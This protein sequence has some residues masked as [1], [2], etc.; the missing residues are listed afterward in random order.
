M[1]T[2]LLA[3]TALLALHAPVFAEVKYEFAPDFLTPPPGKETIGSGHGE[4]G[5]DAAGNIYVSVEGQK[6]GG[7]Q[8]YS[9][10]GKYLRNLKGVP[11]TLHGFVIHKDGDEEFIYAA[12][13][14]Q[15][16][17]LKMK[18]DGTVVLE[19]PKESFPEQQAKPVTIELKGGG[20]VA[21]H[22]S[23]ETATDV[24]V[25]L[26]DGKT[27]TIARD[28]IAKRQDGGLKLTN[29]D[30]APNGDIY[31]VDGYGLSW[32]FVFDKDGK[33]KKVF[34]GPVAPWKLS[35]CHKIFIDPRFQP[36]RLLL[37]DRGNN[38]M[39]HLS[40]DGEIIGV[41]AD[42]GLR[43]PSSA[44]FHGDLVCVAEIAGR[45][46]VWDKEG[47]QVASLGVNDT[48]GQ[49]NTPT[50][51]PID[52]RSGVVTSPHGITFD[53]QGNIMETEWNNFG[54]VLRW[55]VK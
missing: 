29:C 13:L 39:L 27:Q 14:G 46:S 8:V 31:V 26:N 40:L 33:F 30:V 48:P 5:V 37:C 34:G 42:K 41:I 52:W 45:V 3:L 50:V 21:G 38:R 15:Q 54:R 6:E 16:K 2:I 36:V 17:V 4:I 9:P 12:V 1:K 55:N 25:T 10:Q 24:T 22:V 18:L 49:T 28:Q 7:L 51:K 47:N 44:S 19:I 11:G 43:R 32:I 20:K 35:N 53:A 23:A